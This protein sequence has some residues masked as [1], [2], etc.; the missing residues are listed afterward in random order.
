[1]FACPSSNAKRTLLSMIT[2][3]DHNDAAASPIIT[4]RTTQSAERNR[5]TMLNVSGVMAALGSM[6]LLRGR[7]WRGGMVKL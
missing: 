1:L 4:P 6:G 7:R 5:W 2:A 3:H